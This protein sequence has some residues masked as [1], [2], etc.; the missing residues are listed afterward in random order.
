MKDVNC[1][2]CMQ[3][4]LVAAFGY[5]ICKMDSGF[6][7]LFKEQSHPGRVILAHNNHVSELIDLTDEERDQFFADIAKVSRAIHKVFNPN[8]VNYGA[9][10]DTGCHLH[11]HLVPKY[12]NEY[13]WGGVFEMNPGKTLLT[14]AE[15]EEIAEKIRQAL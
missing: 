6:L 7:Y 4:D 8:K 13:E 9:Y 14:D 1:A 5:P 10:G 15:Y 2:Y 11:F 3:G 12:E